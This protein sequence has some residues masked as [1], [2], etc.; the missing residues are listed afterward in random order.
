MS[1]AAM[2]MSHM[3]ARWNEPPMT[4]PLHATM[5]TASRSQSC[6]IPRWPRRMSSWCDMSTLRLPIDPTSRPDDHD[7]PSPRQ[8]T[9]RTS[10][11]VFSSAN[12][13][14]SCVSMSS[15]NALCLSGL[16]LVIVAIGPSIVRSTVAAMLIPLVPALGATRRAAGPRLT[17][18]ASGCYVPRML[19]KLTISP[20]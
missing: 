19:T 15:S 2:R 20:G 16:L 18:F 3:S 1:Y 14:Q 10:G 7:L 5:N 4:H 17:A 13:S 11:C 6:W 8:I 9:A 12:A